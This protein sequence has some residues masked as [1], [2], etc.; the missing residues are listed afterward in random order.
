[1][2]ILLVVLPYLES[3]QVD[4]D[5]KMKSFA[6][7]PYGML[8]IASYCKDVANIKILD[9]NIDPDYRFKM[10]WE[11][12]TFRPDIV[13]F[14]MQFDNSYNYL[15]D[16]LETV[17]EADPEVVTIV[18]GAATI[19]VYKEILQDNLNTLDAVCYGDGEK[20]MRYL[21][22]ADDPRE[23]LRHHSCWVTFWSI[24]KGF[25]PQKDA[26]KDIDDIIDIDYSFV[27]IERYAPR[28]EFSPFTDDLE[29]PKRF[30]VFT[31]FGC[32]FKCSFCYRSRIEDRKMRFASVDRVIKRVKYLVDNYGMKTLTLCDDQLL[33]N[34][35]RAK[36]LFLRLIPFNLRIESY[37]GISVGFIDEDLSFLMR[38]AGMVRAVLPIESG[39]QYVLDNMV[40]K[41][42]DLD[43]AKE[44]IKMLRKHGFWVTA[45]FVMGFPGETDDHR[46]ETLRW[47]QEADL[48]WSTFSAAIPIRGTKL[49]DMCIEGGYIDEVPLGKLDYSKYIIR[50]PGYEPEYVSREIYKMNLR[51]NFVENYAMKQGD[52][53][54]AAK[55]FEW[56]VGIYKNH[57]FAHYYL[58]KCLEKIGEKP[59]SAH[60]HLM[61]Y[62][63]LVGSDR[64]WAQYAKEFGL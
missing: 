15:A 7:P 4:P 59:T 51:C 5:N 45:L 8:S 1:M 57:A 50:T 46:M 10:L 39:C 52:Y 16:L 58:S 17:K 28:S 18:G 30:F 22:T 44:V 54:T 11:M 36:D 14:G 35:E 61:R 13:G 9:C 25:I 24:G 40:D 56:V 34:R 42:V 62:C 47:I 37:Q 33:V 41:P 19:P 26:V 49:Y 38:A 6:V 32:P 64:E 3:N 27:P 53:K 20:P 31:S 63:S 55:T 2:K 29:D 48:D 60:Y 21:A 23:E 12:D 43:H